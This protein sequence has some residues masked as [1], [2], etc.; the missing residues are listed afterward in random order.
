MEDEGFNL[1]YNAYTKR[2]I[3][4]NL[5]AIFSSVEKVLNGSLQ[6]LTKFLQNFRDPLLFIP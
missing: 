4:V 2:L 1:F 6:L 3:I 5:E